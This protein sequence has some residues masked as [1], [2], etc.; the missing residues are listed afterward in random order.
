MNEERKRK[1]KKA[2]YML[3]IPLSFTLFGAGALKLS[4]VVKE[5][6]SALNKVADREC[7]TVVEVS[8]K[9]L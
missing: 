4:D 6:M 1:I 9:K 5:G 3:T 2:A 8:P 7:R